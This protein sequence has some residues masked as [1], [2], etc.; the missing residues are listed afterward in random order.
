VQ[1]QKLKEALLGTIVT[2]L[3]INWAHINMGEY[4]FVEKKFRIILEFSPKI[5]IL[6]Y[7]VF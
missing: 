5:D 2:H 7:A 1:N 6:N 3:V 4:G